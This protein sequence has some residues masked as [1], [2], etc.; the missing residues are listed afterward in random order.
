MFL[1]NPSVI[2]SRTAPTVAISSATPWLIGWA[3]TGALAL[4]L[5]GATRGDATFGATLP[6]WLVGAPLVDLIWV[7]RVRTRR[8][9]AARL[10]RGFWRRG[11]GH[12]LHQFGDPSRLASMRR[13]NSAMMR[14]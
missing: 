13:R 7:E 5:V 10:A 4:L 12:R 1:A 2:L 9:F 14:R 11:T 6:F 8:W 3:A